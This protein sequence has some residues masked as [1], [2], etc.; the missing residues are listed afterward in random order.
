MSSNNESDV[1]VF[2]EASSRW[3]VHSGDGSSRW[4]CYHV[5]QWCWDRCV[6]LPENKKNGVTCPWVFDVENGV[7]A[8]VQAA[9]NGVDAEVPMDI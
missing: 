8:V 3:T 1:H 6:D 4:A 5:L 2:G 9:E 7:R